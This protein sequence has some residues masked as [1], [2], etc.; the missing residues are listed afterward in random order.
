MEGKDIGCRFV[1]NLTPGDLNGISG[2]F[3]GCKNNKGSIVI[4]IMD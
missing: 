1:F 2:Y 4:K 3:R